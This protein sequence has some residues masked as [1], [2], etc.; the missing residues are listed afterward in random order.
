MGSKEL[1]RVSVLVGTAGVHLTVAIAQYFSKTGNLIQIY[2]D[3]E[4]FDE[5]LQAVSTQ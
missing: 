4:I 2:T 3:P 5:R 1:K